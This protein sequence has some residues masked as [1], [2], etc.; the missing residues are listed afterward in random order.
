M[1][2]VRRLLYFSVAVS[3]VGFNTNQA[4]WAQG[5]TILSSL[6]GESGNSVANGISGDGFTVVGASSS[7]GNEDQ[8]FRWTRQ[9]GM[10]GL[11]VVSGGNRS[12]AFAASF[13]GSVIVGNSSERL[14]S[15]IIQNQQGFR[16]TSSGMVGL[17]IPSGA[18]G[19][20]GRAV[21]AEG[22]VIAGVIDYT[23]DPPNP[24]SE[25][26]RWTSSAGAS[27]LG[28]IESLGFFSGA[29][30][31]SADGSRAVGVNQPLDGPGQA[32]RWASQDGM[33]G[34]G[35]LPG[36][37]HSMASGIS[38]D[39]QV[40]VGFSSN[41]DGSE[42]NSAFRWT[43]DDLMTPLFG[44]PPPDGSS[45]ERFSS[46]A[47][48]ASYHGDVIVGMM[49]YRHQNP[50]LESRQAFVWTQ[51]TGA[52]SLESILTGAGVD[53]DGWL[54]EVANGVSSDGMVVVGNARKALGNGVV[55]RGFVVDL[56]AVPEPSSILCLTL[57][58]M[59]MFCRRS[60][61]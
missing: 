13:D 3:L 41:F 7:L 28:H 23:W 56:R 49:G 59:L 48:A 38:G 24:L 4:S 12:E 8:A 2:T 17:G 5:L 44:D 26:M 60:R 11:G 45:G 27:G 53:L 39:G 46:W 30:G 54:L 16:W 57:A 21:S 15:G 14:S 22:S 20:Q 61:R 10:V 36:F 6:Y 58:G 52:R 18:S 29:N 31:I 47:N 42:R 55:T 50:S 33:V 43:E 19:T 37:P 9:G 34:I 40:I 25:A 32:F 1:T 35:T 51:A